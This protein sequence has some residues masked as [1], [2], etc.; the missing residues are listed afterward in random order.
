MLIYSK[1]KSTVVLWLIAL[2]C[3]WGITSSAQSNE[4]VVWLLGIQLY[5]F[6]IDTQQVEH[7]PTSF[8]GNIPDYRSISPDAR[9][10]IEWSE[11]QLNLVL[12]DLMNPSDVVSFTLGDMDNNDEEMRISWLFGDNYALIEKGV[13][14]ASN[15]GLLEF[16]VNS[17]WLLNTTTTEIMEW[18]W[19]CDSLIHLLDTHEIAYLCSVY[20]NFSTNERPSSML[21][22]PDNQRSFDNQNHNVIFGAGNRGDTLVVFSSAYTEVAYVDNIE[23][24]T[25]RIMVYSV[26]SMSTQLVVELNTPTEGGVIPSLSPDGKYL[27]LYGGCF[28]RPVG[29]CFQIVDLSS[30]ETIWYEGLATQDEYQSFSD[31]YWLPTGRSLYVLGEIADADPNNLPNNSYLW[32]VEL[33]EGDG[34]LVGE[35]RRSVSRIVAVK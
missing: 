2:L 30:N 8:D 6:D 22:T 29:A 34:Q 23:I 11:D 19:D 14:K 33:E 31:V 21:L 7:I 32:L 13:M 4:Q 35:I 10:L 28:N 1:H 24:F 5:T 16:A 12:H 27:A 18:Y 15:D 3:A 17:A 9:F 26:D 25:D 20:D